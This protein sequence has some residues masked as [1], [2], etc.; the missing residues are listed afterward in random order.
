MKTGLGVVVCIGF[1]L[2]GAASQ[3]ETFYKYRNE[4]TGRDVFVN[5]LDQVPRKYRSQAKVV[6]DVADVPKTAAGD[7]AGEQDYGQ[8]DGASSK[9][10]PVPAIAAPL[11]KASLDFRHATAGKNLLKDGPAIAAALVDAKLAKSGTNPLTD[12]ERA[13]L[14]SL[15]LTVLV[16]SVVAGLFALVVWIV[17]IVIAVRDGRPW[18]GVF[19]FLFS[20]LA[21]IYIFLHVEKGRRLFKTVCTLGML[22]PALVG[23]VGAWRFYAWFQAVIQARG[24]H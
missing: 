19:I 5:S 24:G 1:V 9:S 12:P 11:R 15:L 3:A 10:S 17:M 20:P 13:R 23:L 22:S 14:G 4:R 2:W 7:Q 21:Y 8:N 6:M 18:W 16:L